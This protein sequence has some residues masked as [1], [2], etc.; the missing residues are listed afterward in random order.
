MPTKTKPKKWKQES[1]ILEAV[2]PAHLS[3]K[4]RPK[5]V[6]TKKK[7]LS[8]VN[9][10]FPNL[11][12][13]EK[14]KAAEGI[15]AAVRKFL[16]AANIDGRPLPANVRARMKNLE[17]TTKVLLGELRNCDDL[18]WEVITQKADTTPPPSPKPRKR[19]GKRKL[20]DDLYTPLEIGPLDTP[21]RIADQLQQY[22]ALFS[23][24]AKNTGALNNRRKRTAFPTLVSELMSVWNAAPGQGGRGDPAFVDF[25]EAVA[26]TKPV[27]KIVP[28]VGDQRRKIQRAI[29]KVSS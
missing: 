18:S 26:K 7:R 15:E 27:S 2:P 25:V 28:P 20:S 6:I 24:A 8:I 22:V 19:K 17:K 5:F 29:I 9:D 1:R 3:R 13:N 16:I 23:E 12:K 10:H 21:D 4:R 14:E 11:S